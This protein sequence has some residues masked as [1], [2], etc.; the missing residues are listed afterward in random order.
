MDMV[1]RPML[2]KPI[3]QCNRTLDFQ[4]LR[5]WPEPLPPISWRGFLL[6]GFDRR[7]G[8]AVDVGFCDLITSVKGCHPDLT[9]PELGRL[10]KNLAGLGAELE[11][12]AREPMVSAYGLKWCERLEQTLDRLTDTPRNFQNWAGAKRLGARDLDPLMALSRPNEFDGFL[13][14]L[15]EL[16]PSKSDGVQALE[17]GVELFLVGTPLTDLLPAS[18]DAQA[19]VTRLLQWRQ[20]ACRARDQE[21]DREVGQWPWPAQVQGQW[22]RIGDQAGLEIRLRATSPQDFAKKLTELNR[23]RETWSWEN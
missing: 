12:E 19:Y 2:V 21:R 11:R 10:V 1:V 20:P 15:A 8:S 6:S 4:P 22:R 17:L 9:L 18:N 14:A 16:N 7:S 13:N 23:I 5:P 3:S